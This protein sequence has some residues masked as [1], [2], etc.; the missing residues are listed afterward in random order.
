[1]I[2]KGLISLYLVTLVSYVDAAYIANRD[3]LSVGQGA[4]ANAMG[5]AF[6][7]VADDPSAM[8]W[9]PAGLTQ[10]EADQFSTTYA[11]RFDGLAKETQVN[12]AWRG[13]KNIWGVGY[14][15]SYVTDISITEALSDEQLNAITNGTFVPSNYATK[16]VLDHA[17]L[18]S[19]ARPLMPDSPHA[20][21]TTIKMIYR[22]MLGMVRGFGSAIDIGYHYAPV[23]GRMRF[24][25]NVQNVASLVSYTGSIN[26]LGV[27]ATA[28]ESY[29][30]T[31]K[32][33]IAYQ[34]EWRVLNGR[35]LL[36]FDAN[37]LTSLDME[38]YRAGIEYAF[39]ENVA[40]RA[41]KIFGRQDDSGEDYSFGMGLGFKNLILDF[42]FL[43]NE[44]GETIRGTIGYKV[45]GNYSTPTQYRAE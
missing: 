24:G 39:G 15:G 44:L 20:L 42:S 6:T 4:R 16:S 19:Y 30:P 43:S 37:M 8:Y 10:L 5:E 18:I 33:G 22:D 3:F 45:G 1:M 12:Y 29:L 36:A 17:I 38:D 2:K 7:G 28:T 27:K 11:D 14:V 31:I 34:P 13:P 41:G 26:N 32:T 9:N 40:L 23:G 21:G 35:V 25:A